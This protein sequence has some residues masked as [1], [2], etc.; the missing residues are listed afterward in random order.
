MKQSELRQLIREEIRKVVNEISTD[1]LHLNPIKELPAGMFKKLMPKTAAT[2]QDAKA[3]IESYV[4]KPMYTHVQYFE[5]QP[6]G[7][8]PDKPTYRLLQHQYY[9]TGIKVNVTAVTVIDITE[10]ERILGKVYVDTKV[11]LEEVPVVF[12]ILKRTS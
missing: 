8:T 1:R 6:K 11:F 7:N 9:Y 12:N 2:T 5:V 4:G 3:R 10:E